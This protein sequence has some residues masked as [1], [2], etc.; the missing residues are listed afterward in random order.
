MARETL[1]ENHAAVCIV[2]CSYDSLKDVE[3]KC[4]TNS[5]SKLI[6]R[7]NGPFDTKSKKLIISCISVYYFIMS[8]AYSMLA[9]FFPSEV[10][11][12]LKFW[13]LLLSWVRFLFY[14]ERFQIA[15]LGGVVIISVSLHQIDLLIIKDISNVVPGINRFQEVQFS[16]L[17]GFC[18]SIMSML[19]CLIDSIDWNLIE[20]REIELTELNSVA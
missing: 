3:C 2:K 20:I 1:E 4:D 9:P 19:V 15:D 16:S 6:Q 13:F 18:E 17:Q 5:S 8:S 11:F 10:R 12:L 7:K 14:L